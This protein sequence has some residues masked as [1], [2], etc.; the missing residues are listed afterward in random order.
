MTG[1]GGDPEASPHLYGRNHFLC[2][3]GRSVLFQLWINLGTEALFIAVRRRILHPPR[4]TRSKQTRTR[5]SGWDRGS[6]GKGEPRPTMSRP[7]HAIAGLRVKTMPQP[8][9]TW[10]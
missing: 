10:G 1:L 9:S 4:R 6:K 8:S 3:A 7:L 5:S 2:L